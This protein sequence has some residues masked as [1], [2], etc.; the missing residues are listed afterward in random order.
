MSLPT[1]C[2]VKENN[3]SPTMAKKHRGSGGKLKLQSFELNP[4]NQNFDNE[5]RKIIIKIFGLA[6]C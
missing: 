4:P 6:K 2:R 5:K 1:P 3:E